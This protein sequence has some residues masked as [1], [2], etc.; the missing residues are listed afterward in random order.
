MTRDAMMVFFK[1]RTI[2]TISTIYINFK[3]QFIDEKLGSLGDYT[4][5]HHYIISQL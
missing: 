2:Y 1:I 4:G 3:R 5:Q